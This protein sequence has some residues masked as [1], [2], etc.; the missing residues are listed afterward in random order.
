MLKE[1][2]GSSETSVLTKPNCVTSQK[3][4]FYTFNYVLKMIKHHTLNIYGGVM[5]LHFT[6]GSCARFLDMTL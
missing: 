5:N 2:L 6:W 3:T 1:A 4:A